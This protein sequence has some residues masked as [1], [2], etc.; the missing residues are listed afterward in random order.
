MAIRKD[1]AV[2]RQL[3]TLLTIGA[4]RNLT[5]G[6]LLERF[7]TGRGKAAEMAFE[8]LVERH[9]AMVLRVCRAQ[10]VDAHAAQDAFQATFLIL[11]K[12][13]HVLW[14]RDSL[15]PW[16]HQVAFR[17]ASCARSAAARRRRHERRVAA[18][19]ASLERAEDSTRFELEQALHEEIN[20]LPECYR[21]PI[22]L[23][24][25]QGCTCE[26]AA[27]RMGRSVGTVKSWRFRGRERLRD[28][29]IRLGLAPSCGLGATLA[30]DV[31]RA[32]IPDEA[33]RAVVRVL[34][35][36]MTAGKVP[37][38]VN[39]LVAGVLKTMFLS[40]LRMTAFALSAMVF[41]TAGIG[42]VAWVAADDSNRPIGPDRTEL[43]RPAP[44]ERF[45]RNSDATNGLGEA[46]P[47]SLRQAIRIGLDNSQ[48]I[49]LV[50]GGD[51]GTPCTVAP[52]KSAVDPERFKAEVM[53]HV[54]T[55]EYQYWNLCVLHDQ[56]RASEK[57]IAFAEEVV[58]REEAK[59]KLDTAGAGS[60]AEAPV[61]LE[62]ARLE[63]VTKTSDVITAERQLRT[64][65][66]LPTAD[67]R[68][69]VPITVPT[70][71]RLEPDWDES[72]ATMLEKQPDVV[73]ARANLKAAEANAASG[74]PVRL[75]RQSAVETGRFLQQVKHQTTHSLAR[76]FLELDANYKQFRT[77]SKLRANQARRLDERRTSYEQGR[78]TV[79]RY[80][81]AVSQYVSAVA[82]EARFKATYNVS[83]VGL[84]EAKGTLLEYD[85]ISLA[86]DPQPSAPA[87]SS[88]PGFASRKYADV[89]ATGTPAPYTR[90]A[91]ANPY[92]APVPTPIA[93]D[94][95]LDTSASPANDTVLKSD[96][97]GQTFSFQFTVGIGPKPVEVRGSFTIGPVQS[98]EAPKV[99]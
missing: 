48:Q 43:A 86:E 73:Q 40:K 14:V 4:I 31:A 7:S 92:P 53:A 23:C 65:I 79:D 56:V 9:G 94:S 72:L 39:T 15:G 60:L 16:L 13:A 2:L 42:A 63:L 21:V 58:M 59:R 81:D 5:D 74:P 6:Q 78:I 36:G 33:V 91:P 27:R 80:L 67:G 68:R 44:I 26:E 34:S 97:W 18:A 49:R 69:I 70:E 45:P 66:G 52:L 57:A 46:W 89:V 28:R 90:E 8:G 29:L 17:T 30:V 50:S 1:G 54:R 75:D 76:F 19:A 83:I 25:L 96:L 24:D 99:Q 61:R 47:L 12:K 95:R 84:E 20:Q 38:S 71:A 3:N 87:R 98:V 64:I 55:I 85:Q 77:A 11:I 51:N 35:V 93:P 82:V 22:I 37:A 88:Q 32:A 10:L 62:Q 41:L